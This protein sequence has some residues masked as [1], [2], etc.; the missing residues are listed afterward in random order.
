MFQEAFPQFSSFLTHIE[1][2]TFNMCSHHVLCLLLTKDLYLTCS[3]LKF[4]RRKWQPTPVLLLRKSHGRRSLVGCSPWGCKESDATDRLHFTPFTRFILYHWR[5]KWQPTPVFLPGE[6]HGRK[7]LVGHGP[8]GLRESDTT[9]VT[10]H[11]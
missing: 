9:E 5:R 3:T 7:S 10:K 8:W 6:S 4:W 2:G 11:A 1:L